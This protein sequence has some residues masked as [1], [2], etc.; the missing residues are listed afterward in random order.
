MGLKPYQYYLLEMDGR[1]NYVTN[2]VVSSRGTA[3]PLPQTADGWQ[4]VAFA[5]ERNKTKHGIVRS[6]SKDLSFVLD[7]ALILR[8]AFYKKNID[9]KLFLLIQK[10][11][12]E[13]TDDF[14]KWIYR[15]L[16]KG[17]LDF[18]TAKDS[19][20]KVD[21]A[22]MEGGL[23][24]Q[25]NA[26]QNTIYEIPFDEDAVN[27]KLDGIEFEIK[28]VYSNPEI[29]V[30]PSTYYF[31]PISFINREGS[32]A[33]VAF[34]SQQAQNISSGPLG[35]ETSENYFFYTVDARTVRVV[36]KI[37]CHFATGTLFDFKF[38]DNENTVHYALSYTTYTGTQEFEFDFEADMPANG[39][40]FLYSSQ[41]PIDINE[42]Q[43]YE[44]TIEILFPYTHQTTWTKAYTRKTLF[45]KLCAKIFGN[46]DYAVSTLLENGD[47]LITS[48]D[49][50]RGITDAVIKTSLSDFYNDVDSDLMT[51][52]G[53]E[54]G[55]ATTN[56]PA[57]NRLTIESREHYYD[58]SDPID[59]GEV[60]D[61]EI[62]AAVDFMANTVKVGW[63]EPDIEDV[64]GKYDFNGS[65]QY[66]T[67]I[68]RISKEY[69]I[70]SSYKAGPFEIEITRINL[71]GKTTTDNNNDN[72][73]F[74]LW[75]ERSQLD[76]TTTA[77]FAA[78]GVIVLDPLIEIVTGQKIRI[79]GSVSND[80]EYT[81]TS[82]V[83]IGIVQFVTVAETIV[84]EASVSI[85][86]EFISGF[87]YNLIRETYD[88]EADPD[89]FGV[90]SPTTIFNIDLSPKRKIKRHGRWLASMLENYDNDKIIFQSG[91][92]NTKLKTEQ[93]STIIREYA[94]LS[95]GGLG[96]K[97][98]LPKLFSFTVNSPVNLGELMEENTN[99]C[100]QFT[101]DGNTYK[102][103][104]M[105]TAL[106]PN[107][108]KEQ[109]YN[110]LSTADNDLTKLI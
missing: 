94:D 101:W 88:N 26:N 28:G 107:E 67:P 32:A 22:I 2:N 75:A 105:K 21:I 59:L 79:T 73:N 63:K 70:V 86:L 1:S 35:L 81:V 52:L 109:E 33:G 8:D 72:D 58:D 7:G 36:G 85:L 108:M 37:I 64:N 48:G 30:D 110:L 17:E 62:T 14:Y 99:R 50:I 80:G 49:A 20:D 74:V 84:V 54:P 60:K 11:E 12:L 15:Y 68:E 46:E 90:P 47:R 57:G 45:R 31:L 27:C 82:F 89:D 71:D 95:V 42:V 24:K 78:D 106:S 56:L 38:I 98:F 96:S 66:T 55:A 19:Q 18:S 43:Y 104:T 29:T 6:F 4:E 93:G 44:S 10:L 97:I 53:I 13:Y 25:L 23:S 3:T 77:T 39:K 16:Y 9:R 65:H 41:N 92:K 100:F 103:F 91:T 76:V 102:G 5:W 51:G 40:L 87:T 34:L 83:N 69:N 61:L